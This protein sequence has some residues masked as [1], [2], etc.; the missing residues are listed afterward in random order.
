MFGKSAEEKDVGKEAGGLSPSSPPASL[1]PLPARAW[2]PTA[3]RQ[4]I[5][6]HEPENLEFPFPTL[7][8][9]HTPNEQFYVR[10]HFSRPTVKRQAWRLKVEGCV[11]HELELDFD[12]VMRLQPIERTIT[13]ECAGNGRIFLTPKV[14]GAQWE[15]GAVSTATWAGVALAELLAQAGVKPQ[16]VEVIF[17]G[18][19]EGEP[20]DPPKPPG[21]IHYAHSIPLS[22]VADAMLAYRMNGELLPAA[23][24]GPLRV[25]VGGWYGMASV[26]WLK[27]IVVSDRRFRGYF[28]SVD[29]AYWE[30]QAGMPI[31]VPITEMQVKAQIARPALHEIVAAGSTYSVVGAAWTGDSDVILV[32]VSTDG[33]QHFSPA[34]LLGEPIRHAW[35]F[36]EYQWNTP[37]SPGRCILMA[38]ATDALGNRQP[39]KR[40]KR[41]GN[42]VV[43]HTLPVE[44]LVK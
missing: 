35:R 24:G 42:Y 23:H 22:K 27:R 31:R 10:S 43:F 33:G 12:A 14:G 18:A 8:T 3:V 34:T 1:P 13:L 4:I 30:Q 7:S 17:E 44:V 40:D 39:A 19:D 32:E 21:K 25:V 36:W 11:D 29:Y 41:F 6:Q 37:I 16:A 15:L 5:R 20:D 28:Q 26:K 2:P 38:R 9:F